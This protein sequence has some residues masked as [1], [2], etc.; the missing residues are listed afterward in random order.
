MSKESRT[1]GSRN[2]LLSKSTYTAINDADALVLATGASK[3][4]LL[5]GF[6]VVGWSFY[7]A[8][9]LRRWCP[10]LES[11]VQFRFHYLRARGGGEWRF[12]LN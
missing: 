12:E 10:R 4:A 1:P 7:H 5:G 2:G 11:C 9:V 3:M 6:R 8:H